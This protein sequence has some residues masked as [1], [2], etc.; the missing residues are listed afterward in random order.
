MPLLK[1]LVLVAVVAG[2]W[3]SLALACFRWAGP[4]R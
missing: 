2:F 1:H 3:S 4:A